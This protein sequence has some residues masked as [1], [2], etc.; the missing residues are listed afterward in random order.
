MTNVGNYRVLE[1]ALSTTGEEVKLHD[2]CKTSSTNEI[3][4]ISEG[5]NHHHK[6]K[7]LVAENEVTGRKDWLSV[8][9]DGEL[10]VLANLSQ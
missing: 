3:L 1:G 6:T 5:F 9:P 8:Y 2:I 10:E 4:I 7:G